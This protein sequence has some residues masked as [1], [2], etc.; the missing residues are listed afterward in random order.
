MFISD[1]KYINPHLIKMDKL[2]LEKKKKKQT[3][4]L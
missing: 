3:K 1:N 4:T 2:Q